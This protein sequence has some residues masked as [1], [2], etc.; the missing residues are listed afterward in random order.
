[1]KIWTAVRG[2]I[3]RLRGRVSAEREMD[4]EL[5]AHVQNRVDDLLRGGLARAEAERRAR[6]EFG[7]AEK[8][9][10]ECREQRGGFWLQTVWS[11]VRYGA[12]VLRKS[13]GFAAIAILTLGLGIGANTAIF[14]VV[15]AVLLKA[16]PYPNA[17]RLTIIWSTWGNETRGPASGPELVELRKR[18]QSF[19]AI[20]GIWVSSG[21][22]IGTSEPEQ[23]RMGFSTSNFLPLL[24]EKPQLGRFF[25]PDQDHYGAAAEMILTDGLWRRQF[26]ADPNIIGRTARLNGDDFTVIGVLPPDFRLMFPEN[27]MADV[28]VFISFR[29]DLRN[30]KRDT[31]F[32]RTIGRLRPGFTVAQAQSE[33]EAIAAQLRSE[34]K[35]Y[36][37]QS[38]QLSVVSLQADDVKPV[39]PALLT[40]FAAV[41]FVLLVTCANIANLLLARA[42]SRRQ[43]TALRT[44]LGADRGRVVRQLLTENI[45]LGVLG[46]VAALAIGWAGL[47][48]ILSLQPDGIYRLIAVKLD[49]RVL[50]FTLALSILTGI[51]FGLAPALSVVRLDLVEI[52]KESGKSTTTGKPWLRQLLIVSEVALGCIVLVGTGLMIRT[53]SSLLRVDP[54]FRPQNV[55]TFQLSFPWTHYDKP[56]SVTNFLKELRTRV[57]AIPGTQSV[58][59]ISHLPFDEGLGN[60]YSYY[61]PEGAPIQQQ[62]TVMADHRSTLPGYF[63]AM[64]ATL[65]AGREF[66]DTDDA[67]HTHVAIIDDTVGNQF[68]PGQN[69]SQ[70]LGKK[71][72]VEDSPSGAFEFIREPVVVIG[73]VKHLQA[74][75]LTTSERGQIYLPVP[76]APR[77]AYTVVVRTTAPMDAFAAYVQQAVK[78]MDREMPVSNLRLAND[79]IGKARAQTRF[80][81]VLAGALGILALFLAC[82]GIYGVTSYSVAQRNRE[83]A[84]RLVVGAK[85]ANVCGLVLWQSGLPVAAG[86]LVGLG[87]A[88]LLT[89]LLSTLLFGVRPGDPLTYAAISLVLGA[90]GVAACY[91]PA[92]RAT[93]VDPMIALRCE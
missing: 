37:E 68:W 35:E 50:L 12:R 84:I 2:F 22:L 21:T 28:Q 25:G 43:E 56:E 44:A 9:K 91:I 79:Y 14:S 4:E 45:F 16:L 72:S 67:A 80:V 19:D 20:G 71:L 3:P 73:V 66:E 75:S 64:G 47:R 27:R 49:G 63:S 23:V 61:W 26:G 32:L 78:E 74:H 18:C 83:I 82:I 17:D 52:L 87:L 8:F 46:G 89:P 40:L 41:G 76:L 7:A 34:A 77:P 62:N 86:L 69:A 15:N 55:V 59:G 54:G 58:S 70:L 11:D 33:A 1:M 13:P 10:E 24:L 93:K 90:V 39:Q 29:D 81:T 6:I 57:L 48:G 88:G 38:L 36:A 42:G 31:A 85:S 5:H 65:L 30:R 60:W 92:R 51:L 53:F